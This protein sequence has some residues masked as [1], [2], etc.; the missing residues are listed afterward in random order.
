LYAGSNAAE[1]ALE[2]FEDELWRERTE[3]LKFPNEKG[4]SA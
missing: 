4:A 1:E 2:K 3:L